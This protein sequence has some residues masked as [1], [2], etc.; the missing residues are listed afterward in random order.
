M[1]IRLTSLNLSLNNC[2]INSQR[3]IVHT[4]LSYRYGS[5]PI[6]PSLNYQQCTIKV[7]FLLSISLTISSK[8]LLRN[9]VPYLAVLRSSLMLPVSVCSSSEW[10]PASV[11]KLEQRIYICC[12]DII[13]FER[14]E[15]TSPNTVCKCSPNEFQNN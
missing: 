12:I 11:R 3:L 5:R 13:W 1:M 7:S 6:N 15:V 2:I 4:Y 14:Y 8:Q 9:H 10:H